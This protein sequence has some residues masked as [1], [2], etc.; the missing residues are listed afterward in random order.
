MNQT[1]AVAGPPD[2]EDSAAPDPVVMSM[3]LDHDLE[4]PTHLMHESSIGLVQSR[5]SAGPIEREDSRSDVAIQT[6]N[7]IVTD[8]ADDFAAVPPSIR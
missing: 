1:P 4:A 3:H 5:L 2:R 7:D 6:E 8:E